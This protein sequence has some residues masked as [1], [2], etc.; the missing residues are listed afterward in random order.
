MDPAVTAIVEEEFGTAPSRV[1]RAEGGLVHDTYAVDVAGAAVVVQ[2]GGDPD[3]VADSLRRGTNCYRLFRDTPVPVPEVLSDGV[4]THDGR[5]YVVVERLPGE[6]AKQEVSA[7]RMRAAGRELAGIHAYGPAFDAPGQLRFEGDQPVVD[8]FEPDYR[9]WLLNEL[10]D[11]LETLR[12]AGFDAVD[13]IAA[14]DRVRAGTL[15]RRLQPGERRLRRR[16]SGRRDRLRP[17]LRR[18]RRP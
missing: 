13:A 16:R 7:A 12:E 15:S 3:G 2:F 11:N 14:P 17:G 5:E 4:G 8:P 9:A 10:R 18:P 1:E 6:S